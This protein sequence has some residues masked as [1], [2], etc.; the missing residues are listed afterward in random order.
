MRKIENWETVSESSEFAQLVPGPQICKILNVEDIADKE[1]LK[2]DFDI[3]GT[4]RA[5]GMKPDTIIKL[6]ATYQELNELVGE[7]KRQDGAFGK[8]PSAGTTYRSYKDSAAKF[9]K[10]FTTAVEK[11]NKG[12]Q[13]AWNEKTLVDKFVVVNFG[14]EEYEKDGSV[15]VSTKAREFRSIEA[16]VNGEVKLLPIKKLTNAPSTTSTQATSDSD[17]PW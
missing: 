12:Y 13:W 11:S 17:L 7:F 15:K 2:I 5:I 4:D 8:W 16:L 14:E 10:S 9:F 1:Y 3:V 6:L